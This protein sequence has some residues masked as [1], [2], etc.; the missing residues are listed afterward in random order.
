MGFV[1]LL[2]SSILKACWVWGDLFN[3]EFVG[4]TRDGIVVIMGAGWYVIFL[5]IR[6]DGKNRQNT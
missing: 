3:L 1:Y 5:V 2:L 4:L 6:W